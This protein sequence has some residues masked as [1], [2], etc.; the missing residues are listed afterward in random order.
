MIRAK[1]MDKIQPFRVM[2]L[3]AEA[4]RLEQ[5]GRSIIH[6]E[7]GE[8]DFIT[9]DP[10]VEAGVLAL[11][12]GKTHY[13]PASGA[14]ALRQVISQYYQ[15]VFN[16]NVPVK[17]I[18]ITPGASGA[19]QL[20]LSVL[21][22]PGDK[23]LMADPGYPC[24]RNFVHLLGGQPQ[25]VNVGAE[26]NF[27]I[28][29]KILEQNWQSD[30]SV[31]LLATPSNPTGT[32]IHKEDMRAMLGFVK[33]QNGMVIVDEIYQGLTYDDEGYSA[34]ELSDDIFV[35][36]SFSKYFGMTGW[37]VGWIVV[38]EA[39]INDVDKLAQNIYLAAATPSQ[40]AALTAFT[41]QTRSI[42]KQRKE[43]FRQRRDYLIPQLRALGFIVKHI[44]EGAFYVYADCSEITSDSFQF[45][46]DVLQEVG[47]AITPGLDFGDNKPERYVRFAYT[48]GIKQLEEAIGRLRKFIKGKKEDA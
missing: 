45:C 22:N 44:P 10:V 29:N 38:P 40:E 6:M 20:A 33:A 39:Y 34:L 5:Q 37:R 32:L 19:L 23:V 41:P 9:P 48:T 15:D 25:A 14:P 13:T 28:S 11:Q 18:M 26:S 1:H 3:L 21:V 8:P 35:I 24:N 42:L 30:S 47:V 31:L 46:Q 4:R 43:E 36:N 27:Q 12:Q 7:V 17:R 16:V 2:A